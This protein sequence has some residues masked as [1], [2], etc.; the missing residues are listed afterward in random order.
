MIM[1]LHKY[2]YN[3]IFFSYQ[4]HDFGKEKSI[5]YSLVWSQG[6]SKHPMITFYFKK[7]CS[8]MLNYHSSFSN[9]IVHVGW[10]FPWVFLCTHPF[11]LEWVLGQ[12]VWRWR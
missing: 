4:T 1:R 11:G 10:L 7:L 6:E 12:S 5:L 2:N 3:S 9:F 8:Y